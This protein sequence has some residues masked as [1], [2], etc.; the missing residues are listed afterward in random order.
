M[1]L[2]KLET[3]VALSDDQRQQMLAPLSKIVGETIGK[4]E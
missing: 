4:S 2:L 3:T 1:P